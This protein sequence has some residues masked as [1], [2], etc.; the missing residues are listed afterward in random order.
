MSLFMISM[1]EEGVT[2]R[3]RASQLT[4]GLGLLP[5]VVVDQHFDQR[6]RYGRLLS[7]VATSPNLLGLGID[8]DTAAEVTDGR[9]L[10]VLGTGAVFVVD[11][12]A[13]VSDVP[14]ASRDAPLL[15]S[16]AVVHSLPTGATF[17]LRTATLRTFVERYPDTMVTAE[18]QDEKD[19]SEATA[20]LRAH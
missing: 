12:R 17:D 1:G 8:E 4:A 11:A 10:T 2:P 16:G 13:A 15:V 19:T 5:D 14:E 9:S 3:Q 6:A 18:V 20:A 7:I